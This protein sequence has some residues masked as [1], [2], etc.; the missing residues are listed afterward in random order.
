[1]RISTLI[2]F[3]AGTAVAA[4]AQSS[5]SLVPKYPPGGT[6]YYSIAIHSTIG[7]KAT[8]DT[9]A[10][11]AITILP[12]AAPGRF[13]A[14][15]RFTKYTTAVQ[16]G[17]DDLAALQKQSSDT[18]QAATTMGASRFRMAAGQFTLVARPNGPQYDQPVEML[19]E[20]V[21]TD[22]LPA[23]PVAVGEHWTRTR[24]R[25]IPTLNFSVPLTL[26]CALTEMAPVNGVPAATVTVHTTGRTPLP[27][28]SLPGSQEL[29]SQG[30]LAEAT[31]G[32]DTTATDHYRL[33]DA[34][35]LESSSENHNSMQIKLVGPSPQAGTTNTNIDSTSTVKLERIEASKGH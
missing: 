1:M 23:V 4:G 34:V 3:F 35:L 18:D 22:A 27:P 20:L 9:T 25:A 15:A 30:V 24:A 12:G 21:R 6:L 16:A 5:I 13:D 31:V 10:E 29:A 7:A 2:I 8:L 17:P 32:F 26:E 14:Q 19:E 33:A 28:G 11:A